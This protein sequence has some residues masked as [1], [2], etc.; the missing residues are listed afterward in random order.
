MKVVIYIRMYPKDFKYV[1]QNEILKIQIKI[2]W[3]YIYSWQIFQVWYTTNAFL[4]LHVLFIV[5]NYHK[6]KQLRTQT[7]F[8]WNISNV[9]NVVTFT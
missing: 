8:S 5:K 4:G 1:I 2:W 7:I 3:K 6:A 9:F